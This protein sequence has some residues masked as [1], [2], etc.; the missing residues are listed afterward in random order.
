MFKINFPAPNL[1]SPDPMIGTPEQDSL[2]FPGQQSFPDTCAIRCQEFILE[3]FTGQ[4]F[5]EGALIGEAQAHGWYTP[6]AGTSPE[7]VGNLLELH[8]I[9]VIR[10]SEAHIFNLVGELAQGHKVIIGIDSG[11]LWNPAQEGADGQAEADHAVVVSGIDT[12]NPNDLR[13]IISDPGTGEA[14]ISYPIRQFVDAWQDSRFTMVATQQPAP[15]HL[16]EMANFDYQLGHVPEIAG[17][18]YDEFMAYENQP[19]LW[20]ELFEEKLADYSNAFPT[21][22]H[23]SGV[24]INWQ[25]PSLEQLQFIAHELETR[26]PFFYQLFNLELRHPVPL[27]F[28]KAP[29][30]SIFPS[31]T[32]LSQP[33]PLFPNSSAPGSPAALYNHLVTLNPSW[34]WKPV[35]E[36]AV[37]DF[38]HVHTNSVLDG[39]HESHLPDPNVFKDPYQAQFD[40]AGAAVD[41]HDFDVDSD[42]GGQ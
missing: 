16:P 12:S 14:A 41:G 19:A 17:V 9:P 27:P 26:N 11:E 21:V 25:D 1:Q 39:S 40:G 42:Q 6:G 8:G 13:V 34:K 30:P 3:Q 24:A 33:S 4:D 35:I 23:P 7:N 28:D 22:Y 15:S 38:Q 31:P 32:A 37:I 2:F 18:P 36:D 20:P 10:Y 5:P 29:S